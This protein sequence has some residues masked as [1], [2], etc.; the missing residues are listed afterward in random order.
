MTD[1]TVNGRSAR[2]A[3]ELL[4][5]SEID[6]LDR[7]IH[8]VST[9][10]GPSSMAVVGIDDDDTPLVQGLDIFHAGSESVTIYMAWTHDGVLVGWLR[11]TPVQGYPL[12]CMAKGEI[13]QE[14]FYGDSVMRKPKNVIDQ[15]VFELNYKARELGVR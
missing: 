11:L 6:E 5:A 15:W 2:D 8:I 7:D 13:A 10:Q 3:S 1:K 12:H 4:N 14:S 9:L